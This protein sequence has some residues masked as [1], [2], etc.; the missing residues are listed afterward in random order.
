MSRLFTQ[1]LATAPTGAF[2][3]AM[4]TLSATVA[5]QS[6]VTVE[7]LP[8]KGSQSHAHFTQRRYS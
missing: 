1:R 2:G 3:G 8:M 7:P 6:G 5:R 4:F